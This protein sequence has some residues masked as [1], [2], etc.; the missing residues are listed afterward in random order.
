MGEVK[1]GDVLL[2][3]QG[4]RTYF[5]TEA[6]IVKAVDDISYYVKKGESVG[7]VGESGSGKTVSALSVMRIVPKPGRIL[8]GSVKF[9]GEDLL[10]KSESEMR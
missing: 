10:L 2:E 7:L 3:V 9:E 1:L 4:L 6:G 8:Q 5:F